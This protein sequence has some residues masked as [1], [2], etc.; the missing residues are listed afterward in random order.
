ME[1]NFSSILIIQIGLIVFSLVLTF[2]LGLFKTQSE[3]RYKEQKTVNEQVGRNTEDILKN[4]YNQTSS[5]RAF[6]VYKKTIEKDEVKTEEILNKIWASVES[7]Q[8]SMRELSVDIAE[9]K[10]KKQ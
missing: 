10:A 4:R 8:E 1:D 9:L 7:L 6:E 3:R 5:V 2:V